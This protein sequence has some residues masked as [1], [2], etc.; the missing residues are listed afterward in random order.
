MFSYNSDQI[1]KERTFG[2]H[3]V[4]QDDIKE[5][6]SDLRDADDEQDFY[7]ELRAAY[8]KGESVDGEVWSAED[9]DQLWYEGINPM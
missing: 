2:T 4:A 3:V 6:R 8:M 9:F 1:I 5:L 7:N